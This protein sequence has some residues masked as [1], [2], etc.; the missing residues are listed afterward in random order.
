MSLSMI[1][2]KDVWSFVKKSGNTP[3]LA[4]STR[5][6]MIWVFLFCHCIHIYDNTV[7]FGLLSISVAQCSMY[8][9][10]QLMNEFV[11]VSHELLIHLNLIRIYFRIERKP[12]NAM[13]YIN[14][15][16]FD[17]METTITLSVFSLLFASFSLQLLALR[18]SIFI[19]L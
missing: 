17:K 8:I 1:S 11:F 15:Q 10:T 12:W 14:R 3:T 6:N 5:Q 7:T 9:C 2:R 18:F 4:P 16:V 13:K 19:G